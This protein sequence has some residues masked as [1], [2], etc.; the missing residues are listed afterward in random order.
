[1][2]PLA[3][4]SSEQDMKKVWVG[5]S[6]SPLLVTQGGCLVT[7]ERAQLVDAPCQQLCDIQR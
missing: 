7:V 5:N 3:Q 6:G 1:M 4:H 2:S